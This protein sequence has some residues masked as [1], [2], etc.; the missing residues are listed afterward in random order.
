M[1]RITSSSTTSTRRRLASFVIA[2]RFDGTTVHK[3]LA[4]LRP[5]L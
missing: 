4:E 5:I 2:G 1:A 3:L